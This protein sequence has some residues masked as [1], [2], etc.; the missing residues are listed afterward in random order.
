MSYQEGYDEGILYCIEALD[1]I[2]Y[3]WEGSADELLEE[4]QNL[5]TELATIYN[6]EK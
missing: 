3:D 5:K 1:A 4:L 2:L 6:K